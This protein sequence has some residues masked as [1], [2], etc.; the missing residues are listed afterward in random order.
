M[1]ILKHRLQ[2][3]FEYNLSVQ[4]KIK[5]KGNLTQLVKGKCT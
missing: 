1:S 4:N 5:G 2:I 3:F